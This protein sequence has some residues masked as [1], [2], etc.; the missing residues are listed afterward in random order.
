M[1]PKRITHLCP[2]C[3]VEF[4]GR[5]RQIYCS[6]ECY[7]KV[8]NRPLRERFLSRVKLCPNGCIEWTGKVGGRGYGGIKV[9]YPDGHFTHLVVH[10]LAYEWALG[11]IPD[12]LVLDHLCLN[13]LCVNPLHLEPVTLAV[14]TLRGGNPPA[15]NARKKVCVRGHEITGMDS[16]GHRFCA[17]CKRAGDRARGLVRIRPSR[18]LGS[19]EPPDAAEGGAA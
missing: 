17:V 12:G 7:F 9:T 8:K 14:N 16:R 13:K 3:E 5:P 1:R 6:P 11:P 4:V 10:R 19:Q 18:A 15:V 2:Q